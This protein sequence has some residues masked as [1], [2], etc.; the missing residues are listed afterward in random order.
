MA[1]S[2][3]AL[4]GAA[5]LAL[6]A[7]VPRP[8]EA[9]TV[10]D[11]EILRTSADEEAATFSGSGRLVFETTVD[12][13][14]VDSPSDIRAF[15]L[16]VMTL[17][18]LGEDDAPVVYTFTY[19]LED[20]LSASGIEPSSDPNGSI[21]LADKD[22]QGGEVVLGGLFLD[23]GGDSASGFCF[24]ATSMSQCIRGGG[25]STGIE[26]DFFQELGTAPIPLPA[27]LPLALTA[28]GG[29]ALWRTRRGAARP[30]AA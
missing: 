15:S 12:D 5:V 21:A 19:G 1:F 7:A 17:G 22:S 30:P 11:L 24:S 10:F 9:V 27:T 26:A 20:V 3:I 14:S 8:A 13:F 28:L 4:L 2:R 18:S 25:T 6:G 29:L 16:E 23:F